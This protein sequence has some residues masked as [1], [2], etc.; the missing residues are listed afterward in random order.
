MQ[1]HSMASP[2]VP[3]AILLAL[4]LPVAGSADAPVVGA[5][6]E[7]LAQMTFHQRIVIR[8]PRLPDTPVPP[9]QVSEDE[10][11]RLVEKKGPRC[12]PVSDIS[13]ATGIKGDSI[14]LMTEDGATLRA[15]FDARC[16]AL[17][18]YRGFYVRQNA[19]GLVCAGRD[20][21]RS[22]SGADCRIKAFKRII[23][24]R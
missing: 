11:G 5:P 15:R 3:A 18:F 2:T 19:D 14:D 1:D 16:P 8:F 6:V 23:R 21:V 13:G 10:T 12:V 7:Q 20:S 4:S 24:R 22:R 9:V 17:D